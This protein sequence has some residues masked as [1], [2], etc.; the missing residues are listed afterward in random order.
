M[1][2]K[3][4]SVLDS[5]ALLAFLNKEGGF[6]KVRSLLRVAVSTREPL[7]MNEINIGEV[8]YLTAR[9][10]PSTGRCGTA[11]PGDVADPAWETPSLRFASRSAKAVLHL[12]AT[13]LPCRPSDWTRSA[14]GDQNLSGRAS[15]RDRVAVALLRRRYPGHVTVKPEPGLTE[16][17]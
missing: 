6:E 5:F 16:M 12:T 8:Y 2:A 17:N 11:S 1:P 15:H 4:R 14:T 13:P 7:F 10:G 9:Y 3:R